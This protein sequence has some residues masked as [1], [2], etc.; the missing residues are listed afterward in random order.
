M[1][2]AV[3]ACG[4]RE[5][6]SVCVNGGRYASPHIWLMIVTAVSISGLVGLSA[7]N[8]LIGL[9]EGADTHLHILYK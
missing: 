6:F 5:Y 1:S 3:L 2:L 8:P 7:M 4:V 9:A